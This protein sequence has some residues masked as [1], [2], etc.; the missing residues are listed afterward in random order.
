MNLRIQKLLLTLA[1]SIAAI[2]GIWAQSYN[3]SP[4]DS[5][6]Q[7]ANLE[8]T[9]V[10]NITQ[11]HPT[12]DTLYFHWRKIE[13]SLP[14]GWTAS[15]CDN[16]AC[17]SSLP[18]SGMMIPIVPG[19]NG[20]MS[21]HCTPH[22]TIGAGIIRYAL[23]ATAT[24]ARIDTLTWIIN[25]TATGIEDVNSAQ[26]FIYCS[27]GVIYCS[28]TQNDY[29]EVKVYSIDG[30]KIFAPPIMDR[31]TVPDIKNQIVIVVLQGE[32]KIFSQKISL[33]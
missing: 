16:G 30:R 18:D 21:L 27:N 17:F 25:A 1:I 33:R 6:V 31:I 5:L 19:D 20:L 15:L 4:G 9:V 23:Y 24:P 2:N 11:L 29:S 22:T 12:S 3:N 13:A 28:N 32:S 26:P 14:A 8:Q 10:M 7:S